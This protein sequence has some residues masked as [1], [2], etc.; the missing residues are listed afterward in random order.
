MLK[1]V[2]KSGASK[3][4]MVWLISSGSLSYGSSVWM[5]DFKEWAKLEDTPLRQHLQQTPPTLTGSRVNNALAW[6]LA[7]APIICYLMEW[8]AAGALNG[9]EAAAARAMGNASYWYI[10]LELN[11]LL[12]FFDEKRLQKAG[13]NTSR[14]RGLGLASAGIPISTRQKS[15]GEPSLLH[16]LAGVFRAGFAGLTETAKC[17]RIFSLL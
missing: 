8:F 17:S 12:S 6:V 10:S 13:H 3:Q 14:F 16:C 1:T 2:G 15:A 7:F 11:L 4:E 9:N 5:S